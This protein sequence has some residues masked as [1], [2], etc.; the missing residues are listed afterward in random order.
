MY[1]VRSAAIQAH[2]RL[3]YGLVSPICVSRCYGTTGCFLRNLSGLTD[4]S[5]I[6]VK[7]HFVSL[8]RVGLYR[9]G[10]GRDTNVKRAQV[11]LGNNFSF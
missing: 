7:R 2:L 6:L 8:H 5:V 4:S 1:A 10:Q 9:C 3:A 11:R